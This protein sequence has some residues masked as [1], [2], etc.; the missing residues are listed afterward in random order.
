M[1]SLF[2]F[3]VLGLLVFDR[4]EASLGDLFLV[5]VCSALSLYAGLRYFRAG[6]CLFRLQGFGLCFMQVDMF[7]FLGSFEA[8]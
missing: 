4:L 8:V 7:W 2:R 5:F 1:L 6:L 3:I